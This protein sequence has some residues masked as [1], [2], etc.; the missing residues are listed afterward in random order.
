MK[1]IYLLFAF[2]LIS[3][4]GCEDNDAPFISIQSPRLSGEY[5]IM[6][7]L[8]INIT[9]YGAYD[10]NSI[11]YSIPDA[12][13]GTIDVDELTPSFLVVRDRISIIGLTPGEHI[14]RVE[15]TDDSG[16]INSSEVQFIV[17]E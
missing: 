2:S 8:P 3:L 7:G 14:L 5:S 15:A 16:N 4:L 11:S 9:F 13:E 12:A 1:S 10:I 17:T 6:D